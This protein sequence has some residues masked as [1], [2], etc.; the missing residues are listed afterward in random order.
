MEAEMP[1]SW[2]AEMKSPVID[3]K[4]HIYRLAA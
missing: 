4:F 2:N 1:G 3:S